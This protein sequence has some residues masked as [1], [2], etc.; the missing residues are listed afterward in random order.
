[1]L[2]LSHHCLEVVWDSLQVVLLQADQGPFKM[3]IQVLLGPVLNL[4]YMTL[5]NNKDE[6]HTQYSYF[7]CNFCYCF[8][9]IKIILLDILHN[10]TEI[11]KAYSYC[12]KYMKSLEYI[13]HLHQCIVC[14]NTQPAD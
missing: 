8:N 13:V 9:V 12:K 10:V 3:M 4:Q 5:R 11:K 2:Q 1:M 7:S 6:Q 14:I